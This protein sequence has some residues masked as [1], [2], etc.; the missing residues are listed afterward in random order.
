MVIIKIIVFFLLSNFTIGSFKNAD[1]KG[2]TEAH[3]FSLV[4]YFALFGMYLYE[5]FGS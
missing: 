1:K 3:A 2:T 4:L 5:V